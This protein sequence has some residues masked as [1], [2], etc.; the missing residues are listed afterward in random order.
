MIPREACFRAWATWAM[1]PAVSLA[2]S[3]GRCSTIRK[4]WWFSSRMVHSSDG[5]EGPP[6]VWGATVQLAEDAGADAGDKENP[7]LLQ[8]G[9]AVQGPGQHLLGG[10]ENASMVSGSRETAG[11]SSISIVVKGVLLGLNVEPGAGRNCPCADGLQLPGNY[12]YLAIMNSDK[13]RFNDLDSKDIFDY[14]DG[15]SGRS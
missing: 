1:R 11:R 4:E 14:P 10:D 8:V 13:C 5:G 15:C 7:E 6:H 2:L 3:L 9:V 12:D